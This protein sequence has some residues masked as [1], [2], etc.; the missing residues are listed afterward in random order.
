MAF[1]MD[2]GTGFEMGDTDILDAQYKAYV[3]ATA[4]TGSYSIGPNDN[5]YAEFNVDGSPSELYIGVWCK[6]STSQMYI[7]IRTSDGNVSLRL[8]TS[9][10]VWDAYVDGVKVDDGAYVITPTN[11]HHVQIHIDIANAGGTFETKIDGVDDISFTGDTQPGTSTAIVAVRMSVSGTGQ[12][13]FYDDFCFGSGGWPGDIRFDPLF[14]DGDT[15]TIN[16][17]GSDGDQ[18]NNYALIDEVP[19]SDADYVESQ[20]DGEQDKYDIEDW[21]DAN[22]TPVAVILWARA[23]KDEAAAHLLKLILD[24]GTEDVDAGHNLQ[25][26]FDYVHRLDETKPSGGAWTDADIDGLEVGI[27]SEIV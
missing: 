20:A 19:P 12:N 25:T 17:D 14:P 7:Y 10:G 2:F 6:R 9:N 8:D 23:K 5:G 24:D 11:W 21:D 3:N 1:S 4:H 16:W 15:A 22:K 18:V 27:E 26:S 13:S